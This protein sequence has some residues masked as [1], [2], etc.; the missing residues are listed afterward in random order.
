M[1]QV[2]FLFSLFDTEN[3]H[4]LLNADIMAMASE[5]YWL[6]TMLHDDNDDDQK[7]Q[8]AWTSVCSFITLVLEQA[9]ED[10]RDMLEQ[11]TDTLNSSLNCTTLEGRLEAIRK[12]FSMEENDNTQLEM[13]LPSLR[14][15]VLTDDSLEHFLQD[16]LPRSFRLEKMIIEPQKSLGREIFETL[17][18]EGKKLA[19]TPSSPLQATRSTNRLSVSSSLSVNPP[20]IPER[21]SPR[22]PRSVRSFSSFNS[23]TNRLSSDLEDFEL[24]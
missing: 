23:S 21:K 16:T 14:M 17:F 22:S 20:A 10:N 9:L 13:T 8:A 4:I 5:L 1:S 11:L 12:L 19:T 15:I 7:Q 18:I 2:A 3:T 6:M 24:I